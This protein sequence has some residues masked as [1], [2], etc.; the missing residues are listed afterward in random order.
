MLLIFIAAEVQTKVTLWTFLLPVVTALLAGGIVSLYKARA[1]RDSIAAVAA[2]TAIDI[3]E[4][5][6]NQLQS[7]LTLSR[8]EA[9]NA[10]MELTKIRVQCQKLQDEIADLKNITHMPQRRS[11]DRRGDRDS[12]N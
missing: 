4:A 6:I 8:A 1:E 9:L 3:F 10:H 12:D 7:D 11:T 2:K 5:S